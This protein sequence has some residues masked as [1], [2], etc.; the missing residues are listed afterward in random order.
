MKWERTAVQAEETACAKVLRRR[1]AW[2]E[3]GAE[4]KPT[5][6]E[7]SEGESSGRPGTG[8]VSR[9]VWCRPSQAI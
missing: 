2:H 5:W 3:A 9:A 6:M 4:S 1:A 7:R 8:V